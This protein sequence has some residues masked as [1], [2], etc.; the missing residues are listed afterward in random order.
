M[1]TKLAYFILIVSIVLLV[2]NL[3]INDLNDFRASDYLGISS[4][5]LLI[6]AMVLTIRKKDNL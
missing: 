3:Y 1:K 6:V 5:V 4:N 2:V